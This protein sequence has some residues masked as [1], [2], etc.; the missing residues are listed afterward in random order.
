MHSLMVRFAHYCVE[1]EIIEN[2]HVD[3]FVYGLEKRLSTIFVSIPFIILAIVVSNLPCAISF[4]LSFF[5]LREYLGGFH[6][7][8]VLACLF[9]SLLSEIIVF[10]LVYPILSQPGIAYITMICIICILILAPYNHPNMHL[11]NE[12]AMACKKRGRIRTFI[13]AVII[14]L[15][16]IFSFEEISKG[17]TLGIALATILLCLGHIFDRRISK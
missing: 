9:F 2:K 17:A 6:A 7:N 16:S 12:E 15:S 4:F 3:W 1:K 13:I 8:S 14:I 11:T 10:F 5:L